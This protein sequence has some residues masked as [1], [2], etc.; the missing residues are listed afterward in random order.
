MRHLFTLFTLTLALSS[1]LNAQAPQRLSYQAVARD[2][3][4]QPLANTTATLRFKIHDLTLNGEV[5]WTEVQT[6]NTNANGLFNTQ[7]GNTTSLESVAWG[8]GAKFLQVELLLSGNYIDLGTQQFL[9]VPYAL[10][11]NHVNLNVST[12]GDTLIIGNGA[13][14]IIPGLSA[15][16]PIPPDGLPHTCG[17]ESVHNEEVT[18]GSV[19][20]YDGN[21]YKTITV[22]GREWMAEN[23][24]VGHFQNGDQ[25]FI[26]EDDNGWAS[27]ILQPFS[28]YYQNIVENA[29]PYGRIYNFYAVTDPRELC[30]VGWH[31]P[32]NGE[33]ELLDSALG[34]NSVAGGKLKTEGTVEDG[35]GLWY[36]PNTNA[37]N[38]SG[39]SAVP[40]GYRSQFGTFAQK[41]VEAYYWSGQSA[42]SNDGWYS[43]LRYDS[44]SRNGNIFDG[45]FGAA[46]RCIRDL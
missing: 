34:G 44:N 18:Y 20:D 39:F 13:P 25:I 16:N 32:D 24:N 15:A 38:M 21:V 23:L 37:T 45:R 40:G 29:C 22:N 6:V 3:S 8:E 30:P 4:G 11:A 7:L 35:S 33:W 31:V 14:L 36:A 5:I 42:G 46:V 12:E 26:V 43:R 17:L 19:T 2:A 41:N 9:S 27:S 28:C 1:L 10:F